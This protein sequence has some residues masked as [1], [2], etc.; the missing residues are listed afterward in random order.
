MTKPN[1]PC[2][3]LSKKAKYKQKNEFLGMLN[4]QPLKKTGW[5]VFRK[6]I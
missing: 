3:M 4:I 1:N 5:Q 6:P 2:A